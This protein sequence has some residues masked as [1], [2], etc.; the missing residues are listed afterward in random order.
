VQELLSHFSQKQ[1]KGE[2]VITVEGLSRKEKD[3][4]EE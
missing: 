2:I 4:E 1:V 3:D